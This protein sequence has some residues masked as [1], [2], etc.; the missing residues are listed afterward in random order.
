MV[1]RPSVLRHLPAGEEEAVEIHRVQCWEGGG[2]GGVLQHV[3]W[4]G[5]RREKNDDS[6][7]RGKFAVSAISALGGFLT[8]LHRFRLRPFG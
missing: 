2:E 3:A 7:V 4:R 6:H 1:V 8:K 5:R